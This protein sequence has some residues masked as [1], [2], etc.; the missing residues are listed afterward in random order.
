M[1]K[2]FHN[3]LKAGLY[4][5]KGVRNVANAMSERL[6]QEES[7]GLLGVAETI[8]KSEQDLI[9]QGLNRRKGIAGLLG[10][11]QAPLQELAGNRYGGYRPRDIRVRQRAERLRELE[12]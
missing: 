2:K 10:F 12:R 11:G 3:F 5:E 7:K 4:G 9:G 8:L 1:L 6:A